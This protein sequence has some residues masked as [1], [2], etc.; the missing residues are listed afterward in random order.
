MPQNKI[1]M[2]AGFGGLMR[3]SEEYPS[4]LML[5]P[6]HIIIFIILTIA[7]VAALKIFFP[8]TG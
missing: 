5:K 8:I 3:Y 7:F 6:S 4:K 2:P 1:N